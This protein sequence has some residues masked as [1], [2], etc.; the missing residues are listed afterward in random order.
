MSWT[1]MKLGCRCSN[2]CCSASAGA[3]ETKSSR[4]LPPI[5]RPISSFSV[6]RYS[7]SSSS[8][9]VASAV[10]ARVA[11]QASGDSARGAEA[12]GAALRFLRRA[13]GG[14]LRNAPFVDAVR[15]ARLDSRRL[16]LVDLVLRG[17]LDARRGPFLGRGRT[18]R[19]RLGCVSRELAAAA[20]ITHRKRFPSAARGRARCP[21]AGAAAE[22]E[23]R[24]PVG[25]SVMPAPTAD[26]RRRQRLVTGVVEDYRFDAPANACERRACRPRDLPGGRDDRSSASVY[27]HGLP[28]PHR[29]LTWTRGRASIPA[30][31]FLPGIHKETS[32]VTTRSCS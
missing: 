22:N 12:A 4:S 14:R 2:C 8:S 15:L 18:R 7:V 16:P 23:R 26:R 24:R 10:W 32:C 28:L 27:T 21:R 1:A 9:W 30:S 5:W 6:A 25:R 13:A 29:V 3:H 17:G 11:A 20:R 31:G 19:G